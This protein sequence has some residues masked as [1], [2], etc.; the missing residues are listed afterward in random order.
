LTLLGLHEIL[1]PLQHLRSVFRRRFSMLRKN[2]ASLFLVTII[3]LLGASSCWAQ[4][5]TIPPQFF[6]VNPWDSNKFPT[7]SFGMIAHPEFAW[8]AIEN[9]R[10]HYD[11]S[12]IDAFINDARTQGGFIDPNTNTINMGLTLGLTPSWAVADQSTCTRNAGGTL[13]QCAAPPDNIADWQDF[14]THLVQ[15][16]NGT[17]QPHMKF[18]E[19]W[20]EANMWNASNN[21]GWWAGSLNDML[22]LALVAYPIIHQD[23][24]SILLTPSVTGPLSSM[25]SWMTQYLNT[26]ISR[27][28]GGSGVIRP[29]ISVNRVCGKNLADGGAFHGYLGSTGTSPYP[30]PEDDSSY[31]SITTRIT[32]MRAVFDQNGLAGKPM[33]QTEGSWGDNNVTQSDIQ[34]A[35]LARWYLLQ[36]SA[37]S[38]ANLQTA[39]WFAWAGPPGWG[40]IESGGKPTPAGSAY[41]EIYTWVINTSPQ[42]CSGGPD[43]TW[44]CTFAVNPN[45]S[46]M[47][48]WNTKGNASFASGSMYSHYRCLDRPECTGG[49]SLPILPSS[50]VTIGTIPILLVGPPA[51]SPRPPGPQPI[52]PMRR[53]RP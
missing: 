5:P 14:I 22:N 50:N 18:Y 3:V 45:V 46:V 11:F 39:A 36:A 26:C 29:N 6:A 24:Y 52:R 25:T 20:N 28:L 12:K 31:G 21:N 34:V 16:Y 2:Y 43:G 42:P 44:T 38:W 49:K 32:Q 41:S 48:V 10:G 17:T 47:A 40:V 9:S 19:L 7:V 4:S 23:P 51:I 27:P 15:H 13:K 8:P 53:R 33:F 30:M 35:W 37:Y 1:L